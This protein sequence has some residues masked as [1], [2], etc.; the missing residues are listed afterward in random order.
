MNIYYR[1]KK[2]KEAIEIAEL[3]INATQNKMFNK[4]LTN[5]IIQNKY[6]DGHW[7]LELPFYVID[8][9]EHEIRVRYFIEDNKNGELRINTISE[10]YIYFIKTTITYDFYY[11]I[12]VFGLAIDRRYVNY[13]IL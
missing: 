1:M 11:L 2:A 4:F 7:K 9:D 10:E 8:F 6:E 12:K 3:F 13:I 5:Y